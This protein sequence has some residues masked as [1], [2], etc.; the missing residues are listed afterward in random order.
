[1]RLL[2]VSL[3]ALLALLPACTLI[4]PEVPL[5]PTPDLPSIQFQYP[6]NNAQVFINT[7]LNIELVAR[8]NTGGISR[9]E[10]YVGPLAEGEPLQTIRPVDA[11]SVPVFT[12]TANWLARPVGA[13]SLTAVAYRADGVRSDETTI[14]IDV[15]PREDVANPDATAT[16]T[17]QPTPQ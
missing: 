17:L 11:E 2:V 14:L 1:V 15:I 5:T 10:L 4:G 3:L 9:V 12:V 7:D 8:D 6:A 16:P 13:T